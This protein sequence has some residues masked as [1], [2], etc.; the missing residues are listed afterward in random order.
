MLD[1]TFHAACEA[2]A[3]A[4]DVPALA[5]GDVSIG[6]EVE[7]L[8]DRLRARAPVPRR[9]G[10]EAVHGDARAPSCSISRTRRAS[11]RRTCGSGTCS[12]IR[13]AS[14][15]ECGD[16][17]PLRRRRRRARRPSS[18]SCPS[19]R[20]FLAVEQAWSYANSGYWLTGLLCAQRGGSRRTRTPSPTTDPA[21]ARAR[22]DELRRA[23]PRGQRARARSTGRTRVRAALPA[24]SSRTS[25][26]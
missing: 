5:V 17:T 16:L 18:P 1:P 9:V 2:A 21:A 15:R 25:T 24:G 23:R 22:V 19:V 6:G 12:P 20:R 3:V 7:T 10:D 11:G 8:G 4:W 13:A 26:T 14:T